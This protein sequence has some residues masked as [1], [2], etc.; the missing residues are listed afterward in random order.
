MSNFKKFMFNLKFKSNN[1]FSLE[2]AQS[3]FKSK[4]EQE[5]SVPE[6]SFFFHSKENPI[7]LK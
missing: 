7:G 4:I 6:K 1:I 5:K 3:R 2:T